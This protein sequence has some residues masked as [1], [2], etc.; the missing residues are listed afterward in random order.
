MEQLSSLTGN[1]QLRLLALVFAILLAVLIA[2]YYLFLRTEYSVLF[3]Q[4]RPDDVAAVV[5]E[6]DRQNI[7]HQL[8]DDGATILVPQEQAAA[9]RLAVAASD[10]SARGMV[11]FELF[12]ES[13]MGLTD[14]AQRVNYQRALQGELARTIMQMDGI[15]RSRVHLALPERS[16]FR[17]NRSTPKAAVTVTPRRGRAIDEARVAGIQR[18]VAAAVPDLS[19][20]DVV[21]LDDVGRMI[22]AA[23]PPELALSPA[24][25]EQSAVQQYYRARAR[26]AVETVL[27]G[28]AFELR[29]ITLP[30]E[31]GSQAGVEASAT[32]ASAGEG[33]AAGA[34]RNFRLRI[35]L[36][37]AAALSPGD[38]ELARSAVSEAVE[39]NP[40]GGDSLLLTVAP[41]D[42]SRLSADPA[43][44]VTSVPELPQASQEAEN[45]WSSWWSA[46]AIP[47][48]II[49]IV[50][51]L[52]ARARV[53][54]DEQRDAFIGRLREQIRAIDEG[55]DVRA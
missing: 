18:L 3:T 30:S 49:L 35:V 5:A 50:A 10:L 17:A 4:A 51:L 25:E 9:A 32:P 1:R 42:T 16:L 53:M 27:P 47:I 54:S 43:R 11:G 2:A 39:L 8:R 12:N 48:A 28:L 24:M 13:D 19:L 45:A 40:D 21:V 36:L 44:R 20:T 14:F 22:S 29:V 41:M 34:Q 55:G 37:T 23:A 26:A 38:Q 31:A 52:R 15:E 33:S 46:L 7:A 6:L